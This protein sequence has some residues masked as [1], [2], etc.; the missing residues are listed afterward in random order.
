MAK[1]E[2]IIQSF[3]E[4][5]IKKEQTEKLPAKTDKIARNET[6][7]FAKIILISIIFVLVA[8]SL[9]TAGYFYS[10]Y[11]KAAAGNT[12]KDEADSYVAKI[13]KF[14]ALPEGEDPTLATVSDREKLKNQPFFTKAENGDKVLIYIKS[15]K[16]ILF[17]PS[18]NKIIEVT[19]L[20][21]ELQEESNNPAVAKNFSETA[22][23][24]G[25][26][27]SG[28]KQP[29]ETPAVEVQ[30]TPVRVAIY[31]G[32]NIKGLAAKIEGTI[33]TLSSIQIQVTEKTNAKGNYANTLIVDL[34]G[35]NGEA[36]E[37][38]KGAA[39]GEIGNFPDGETRPDADILIISGADYKS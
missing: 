5:E 25:D 33:V 15:Q 37:K 12:A 31:N 2:K 22:V 10:K 11:R 9:G 24:N 7:K 36:L 21:G 8:G 34:S 30:K 18:I 1:K 29:S 38:I 17:R 32:T 20:T 14:M 3:L 13:S 35:G 4:K 39:G 16:A 23:N 26:Q 28:E 6:K 19:S 27:Q